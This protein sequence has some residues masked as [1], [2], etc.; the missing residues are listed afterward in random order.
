MMRQLLHFRTKAQKAAAQAQAAKA[1]AQKAT[2][3]T[4]EVSEVFFIN[5]LKSEL[6]TNISL[7]YL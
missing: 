7:F 6:P 1:K 3:Q 2:E 5:F 4:T